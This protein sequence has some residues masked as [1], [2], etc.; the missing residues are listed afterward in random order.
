MVAA[1]AGSRSTMIDRQLWQ[2]EHLALAERHVAEGEHRV[3]RQRELVAELERAEHDVA[4]A[5]GLLSQF[6][7]LLAMHVEHRDRLR[8]ELGE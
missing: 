1:A 2:E 6:E 4:D 3:A 5:R 8:S 7:E